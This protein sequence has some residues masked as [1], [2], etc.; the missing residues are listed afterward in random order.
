MSDIKKLKLCL[1]DS[2]IKLIRLEYLLIRLVTLY[3]KIKNLSII[4]CNYL[5]MSKSAV[6]PLLHIKIIKIYSFSLL[7]SY[8]NA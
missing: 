5:N 1:K 2:N 3:I 4:K 6:F 7:F 8:R